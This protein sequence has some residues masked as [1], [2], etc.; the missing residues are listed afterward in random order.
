[1]ILL[2]GIDTAIVL[3]DFGVT[4]A[5]IATGGDADSPLLNDVDVG[6]TTTE[7]LWVLVPPLVSGGTT[8]V[9]D[10]GMYQRL[11]PPTGL[12]IQWYRLLAMPATSEPVV[13]DA[14]IRLQVGS[15]VMPSSRARTQNLAASRRPANLA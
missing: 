3:G 12:E 10:A 14:P 7:L 15:A 2:G 5:Q 11:A 13:Q 9:N 6:D 8:R 1:M 4:A